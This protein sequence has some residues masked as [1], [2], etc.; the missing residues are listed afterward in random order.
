MKKISN[1][2]LNY[3]KKW[4]ALTPNNK[5]VV[6]S[7]ESADKLLKKVGRLKNKD[8]VLLWVPPFDR[9]LSL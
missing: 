6:V 7:A 5:R 1:P 3:E 8:V 9:V 2:L 4:V